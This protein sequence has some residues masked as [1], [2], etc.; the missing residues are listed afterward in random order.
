MIF[1]LAVPFALG[2]ISFN[3]YRAITISM[4]T[5]DTD[6]YASQYETEADYTA[7]AESTRQ[8]ALLSQPEIDSCIVSSSFSVCTNGFSLETAED[9]CLGALLI[10]NQFA[11]LQNCNINTVKLPVK[12]KA[13]NLGNGMWLITSASDKFDIFLSEMKNNDP[14]RRKRLPG[15]KTCVIEL[16]CGTKIE[17][18]IMEL[19]ADMFSCR[20]DTAVRIDVNRTDLLE[21]LFSKIPSL[22]EMPHISTLTKAIEQVIGKVQLELANVPDYHRK[23]FGYY[24]LQRV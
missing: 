19:R 10:E 12:E 18:R 3:L 17:T 8:I 11:A 14:R 7:I 22:N 23:L 16:Q 13:K 4:P 6:G 21:N 1:R 5:N 24:V 9:T 15:C 2:S 20:H